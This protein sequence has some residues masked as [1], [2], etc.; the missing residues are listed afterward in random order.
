MNRLENIGGQAQHSMGTPADLRAH[1]RTSSQSDFRSLHQ[2]E[3]SCR[4]FLKKGES[5]QSIGARDER[6][7]AVERARA[8]ASYSLCTSCRDTQA[9]LRAQLSQSLLR[10]LLATCMNGVSEGQSRVPRCWE[11]CGRAAHHAALLSRR[12]PRSAPPGPLVVGSG[13]APRS[14][15]RP[16]ALRPT[17]PCGRQ[18][19]ARLP[20]PPTTR[21]AYAFGGGTRTQ[22]P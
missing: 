20:R 9:H 22:I 19:S 4:F 17:I 6:A 1:T 18:A 2:Q 3:G 15:P 11:A 10:D 13:H 12:P 8:R 21:L 5:A 16:Q 7:S 14:W